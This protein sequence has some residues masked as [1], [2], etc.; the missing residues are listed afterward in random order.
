MACCPTSSVRATATLLGVVAR[1]QISQPRAGRV[2]EP[3][4][5]AAAEPL[6]E[7]LDR[8]AHQPPHLSGR[9]RL[10]AVVAAPGHHGGH[11]PVTRQ[12]HRAQLG[13]AVARPAGPGPPRCSPGTRT[14]PGS[15]LG[16]AGSRCSASRTPPTPPQTPSPAGPRTPPRRPAPT[17][18]TPG[19]GPPPRRTSAAARSRGESPQ[20]CSAPSSYRLRVASRP[21]SGPPAPMNWRGRSMPALWLRL[22]RV[23]S[24]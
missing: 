24:P 16:A 18:P 8:P 1:D 19:T 17:W 9:R 23:W 14:P 13:G 12:L 6:L 21:R 22:S 4:Q 5:R 15:H 10:D 7:V 20:T 11:E 2:A 3:V